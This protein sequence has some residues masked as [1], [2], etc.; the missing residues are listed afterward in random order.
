MRYFE[1]QVVA[2]IGLGQRVRYTVTPQYRGP[3][4]V[5]VTFE[6]KA[7]GVTKYGTPGINLYEVVPNSVYSEK[8]GWRN[9]GVV[10]HD[11]K[12]EPMGAMS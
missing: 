6:M 9:L 11:N 7:S 5:P 3:R 8:Y 2:A 12:I 1:E 10:F 4:T